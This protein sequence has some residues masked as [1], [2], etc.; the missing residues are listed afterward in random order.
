MQLLDPT[1]VYT[2]AE[3]TESGI[4]NIADVTTTSMMRNEQGNYVRIPNV[5]KTYGNIISKVNGGYKL[6]AELL[7]A[8]RTTFNYNNT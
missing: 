6:H 2:V 5:R 1:K 4:S 8:F 7:H 3:I